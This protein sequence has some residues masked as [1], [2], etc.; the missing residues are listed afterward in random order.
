MGLAKCKTSALPP[1]LSAASC[2]VCNLESLYML[3]LFLFLAL[4]FRGNWSQTVGFLL[5][6]TGLKNNFKGKSFLAEGFASIHIVLLPKSLTLQRLCSVKNLSS[7]WPA[8]CSATLDVACVS[9]Q[10]IY[11]AKYTPFTSHLVKMR[12]EKR[13]TSSLI[14]PQHL[15]VQ[16]NHQKANGGNYI[17]T[18]MFDTLKQ[19]FQ[20]YK[21]HQPAE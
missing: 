21:Q 1:I 3:S 8:C 13:A 9:A 19:S 11:S 18:F 15:P 17:E 14:L 5:E 16:Q 20:R 2:K 4:S 6:A 10:Q 7:C 12:R